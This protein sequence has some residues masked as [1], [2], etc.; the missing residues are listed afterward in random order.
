MNAHEESGQERQK[1]EQERPPAHGAHRRLGAA[2]DRVDAHAAA[3]V[4]FLQEQGDREEVRHLPDEEHGEQKERRQAE[5]AAHRR[6]ADERRQRARERSDDRRVRRHA[7]ER[8]VYEH[9]A[10]EREHRERAGEPARNDAE[11]VEPE[12]R[13]QH[14]ETERGFRAQATRRQRAALRAVHQRV[15]V[16]LRVHVQ[17][18]RS[19]DHERRRDERDDQ[20]TER[21]R[22]V[23]DERATG[24]R[25]HHERGEARLGELEQHAEGPRLRRGADGQG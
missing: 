25:H 4:V 21:Q 16:A 5:R 6:V 2:R 22:A 14:P 23:R 8:R 12:T 10:H 24:R 19:A 18:V 15:G 1:D 9:V 17:R 20:A 11:D 3:P 13:R 7:L